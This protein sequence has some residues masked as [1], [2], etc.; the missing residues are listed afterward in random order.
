MILLYIISKFDISEK[1]YI[2]DF[3]VMKYYNTWTHLKKAYIF[4]SW[5][6]YSRRYIMP[7]LMHWV[8]IVLHYPIET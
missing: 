3:C 8:Y 5:N 2:Y 1:K 7:L 6:I 4:L